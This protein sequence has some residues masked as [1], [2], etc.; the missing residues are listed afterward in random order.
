MTDKKKTDHLND[1]KKDYNIIGKA[2]HVLQVLKEIS[3]EEHHVT[4]KD[5]VAAMGNASSTSVS[6]ALDRII[7]QL[8]PELYTGDNDSE[9]RIKYSGYDNMSENKVKTKVEKHYEGKAP[10]ITKIRFIHDFD[11]AELDMLM[12][13]VNFSGRLSL[14]EKEQLMRKIQVTASKYYTSPFF[15][16]RNGKV[17][18]H[19]YG[20]YTRLDARIAMI[21]ENGRYPAAQTELIQNIKTIQDAINQRRQIEFD[22]NEYTKEHTLKKRNKGWRYTLSPY[23]IVV[24]HELYYLI[25]S[26]PGKRTVCHFRIDLMSSVTPLPAAAE[27]IRDIEGLPP[28]E[29]WDP[30]KYM[31]EHLYMFYDEPRNIVLKIPSGN[32]TYIHDHF[33]DHY[34]A[35]RCDDAG[36]DRIEVRCSAKAM[37]IL[38]MQ[39]ADKIEVMDDEVRALIREKM[40]ALDKYLK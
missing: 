33:G 25:A 31:R 35:L 18:F 21:K 11:T 29:K 2:V 6:K 24:Y 5:I 7:L 32:Y 17:K 28:R 10:S 19:H 38:A 20:I 8:N 36:F 40:K 16:K 22:F 12:D 4:H 14:E 3:D 13:A 27:P 1:K 39:Y 26:M 34:R 30:E 15:D 9:Y 23:Y 37:A